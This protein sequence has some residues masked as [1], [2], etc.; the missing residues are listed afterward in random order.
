[1]QKATHASGAIRLG[2]TLIGAILAL[3]MTMANYAQRTRTSTPLAPLAL[4]NRV[5]CGIPVAL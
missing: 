4:G 5:G 2:K 3:F 1:M